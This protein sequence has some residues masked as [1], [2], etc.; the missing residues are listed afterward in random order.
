MSVWQS[1]DGEHYEPAV[2][3]KHTAQWFCWLTGHLYGING[4]CTSSAT[5][6][7]TPATYTTS[8]TAQSV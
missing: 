3:I 8:E 1:R 2:P 6:S 4:R 5:T 7:A